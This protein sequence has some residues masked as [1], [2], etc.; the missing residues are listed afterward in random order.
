MSTCRTCG[1]GVDSSSLNRR[2]P[3][4]RRAAGCGQTLKPLMRF[5]L[6]DERHFNSF[7]TVVGI[8]SVPNVGRPTRRPLPSLG[9]TNNRPGTKGATY[10][11]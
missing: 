3:P 6:V 2:D 4:G 9:G 7:D 1:I 8:P 10:G 5:S 11:S